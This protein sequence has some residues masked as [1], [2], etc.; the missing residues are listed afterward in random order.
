GGLAASY[1]VP[2]AISP[3]SPAPSTLGL[4]VVQ[5]GLLRPTSETTAVRSTPHGL[6]RLQCGARSPLQ[7]SHV[8]LP[9]D[10]SCRSTVNSVRQVP[11][12]LGPAHTCIPTRARE[13]ASFSRACYSSRDA[14][15]G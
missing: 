2:R 13:S 12:P 5:R 7:H 8:L 14:P 3:S 10:L 11:D 15:E 9:S 1:D 4:G 6:R